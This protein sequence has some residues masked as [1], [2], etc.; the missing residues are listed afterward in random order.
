[1]TRNKNSTRYY[2]KKQEDKVAKIVGG[3]TVSNSGAVMFDAGDVKTKEWLIE[4]K[5]KVK[6]SE[7]ISIKKS[8]I[9][10]LEEEAFSTGKFYSSL[11]FDFGGGGEI[12]FIIREKEF[13]RILN[14]LEWS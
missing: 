2:S 10:K 14:E 4:C 8:W 13:K 1:M 7:S 3:K 11:A 5:T 9:D 6:P 12:Y